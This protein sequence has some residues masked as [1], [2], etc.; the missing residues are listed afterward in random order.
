MQMVSQQ[1]D[2]V[3]IEIGPGFLGVGFLTSIDQNLFKSCTIVELIFSENSMITSEGIVD[4]LKWVKN[5][6][7]LRPQLP[8]IKIFQC[9]VSIT[10]QLNLLFGNKPESFSVESFFIPFFNEDSGDTKQILL[11]RGPDFSDDFIKI[12]TCQDSKGQPMELDIV[13]KVYF[14]FLKNLKV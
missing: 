9:P 10:R 11:K 12:P 14:A 13:P 6:D 8:Q 7:V 3:K 4:W 1:G 2:R 5:M